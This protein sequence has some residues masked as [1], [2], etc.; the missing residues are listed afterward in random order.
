MA[1]PS[2]DAWTSGVLKCTP[3]VSE[4]FTKSISY[5]SSTSTCEVSATQQINGLSDS[6]DK[7]QSS[8]TVVAP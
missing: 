8:N 3:S 2:P 5:F 6:K 4:N 7:R 1:Q